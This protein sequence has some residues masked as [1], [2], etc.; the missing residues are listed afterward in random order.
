LNVR[1][2]LA[3]RPQSGDLAPVYE[4]TI[5]TPERMVGV[6]IMATRPKPEASAMRF[7][8]GDRAAVDLTSFSLLPNYTLARQR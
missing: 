2:D 8:V 4:V 5:N 1:L 3:H 7:K 6:P